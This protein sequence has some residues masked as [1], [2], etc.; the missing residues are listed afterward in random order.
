M[1]LYYELHHPHFWGL[2]EVSLLD[3]NPV[4]DAD[5]NV[6][7]APWANRQDLVKMLKTKKKG[8]PKQIRL[9]VVSIKTS[10]GVSLT[11]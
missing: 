9:A 6:W 1:Q 8:V 7:Y 5:G 11:L 3:I 10:L 2:I 4:A